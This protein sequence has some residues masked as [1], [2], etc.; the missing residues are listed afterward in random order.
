MHGDSFIEAANLWPLLS[1]HRSED[2]ICGRLADWAQ[3]I[4]KYIHKHTTVFK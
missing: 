1:R 4:Y 3:P 2:K